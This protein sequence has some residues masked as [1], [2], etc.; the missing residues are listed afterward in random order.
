MPMTSCTLYPC[1]SSL[2][3][4]VLFIVFRV[5]TFI[6]ETL[7]KATFPEPTTPEDAKVYEKLSSYKGSDFDDIFIKDHVEYRVA[8]EIF[9]LFLLHARVSIISYIVCI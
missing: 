7:W 4:L 2:I 1:K 6:S 9:K 8:L 3:L 5:K